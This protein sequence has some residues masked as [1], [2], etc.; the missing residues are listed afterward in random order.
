MLHVSQIGPA[1]RHIVVLADNKL[2][3]GTGGP[4]PPAISGTTARYTIKGAGVPLLQSDLMIVLTH[5]ILS[6]G[7]T[8]GQQTE[9]NIQ[10]STKQYVRLIQDEQCWWLPGSPRQVKKA[11]V[12]IFISLGMRV[13][14][15]A[16]LGVIEARLALVLHLCCAAASLFFTP[17]LKTAPKARCL[18]D[19]KKKAKRFLP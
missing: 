10:K 1:S 7:P 15:H 11:L 17:F 3:A 18:K 13:C 19:S 4:V 12:C 5:H 14:V 6:W 8:G 9:F 16:C 2:Y